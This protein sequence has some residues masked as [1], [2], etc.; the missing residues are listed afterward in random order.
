MKNSSSNNDIPV[1]G[2]FTKHNLLK[3]I[4]QKKKL[5]NMSEDEVNRMLE[6]L[7]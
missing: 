5:E 4:Y 2:E 7:I 3:T 6:D 1:W